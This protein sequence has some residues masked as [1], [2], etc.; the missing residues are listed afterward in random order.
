MGGH[1]AMEPRATGH[2]ATDHTI[3]LF[4]WTQQSR[5]QENVCAGT[6]QGATS[7]LIFM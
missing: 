5:A 4:Q 2:G 1:G 3:L 6:V 7:L